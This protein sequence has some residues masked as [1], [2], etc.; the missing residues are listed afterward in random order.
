MGRAL[1]VGSALSCIIE[2][3]ECEMALLGAYHLGTAAAV[4]LSTL[5]P[6]SVIQIDIVANPGNTAVVYLGPSTVTAAGVNAYIALDAG[7]SWGAKGA[8]LFLELDNIYV[9][10]AADDKVHIAYL[11]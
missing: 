2:N 1:T 10:A 3:K 8:Q 4:Q 6:D 11:M 5:V 9:I 7:K